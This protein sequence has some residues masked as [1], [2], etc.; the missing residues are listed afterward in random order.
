M[1][2]MV[3]NYRKTLLACYL[4]FVTQAIA[5]NFAP[6]LFLKFHGD[7]GIPLGQIALISTAFFLTQLIVDVLC[8]KFT[9]RIGYRTCVVASSLCF[10]AGLAGLAFLPELFPNPFAGILTSVVIYAVGSGLLE[11]L[12]SPIVEACPFDHKEAVMSLLHSFYCWGSVATIALSTLFFVCFG[13]QNWRI[14]AMLWALLPLVN[15]LVFTQVPLATLTPEG[16]SGLSLGQLFRTPRFWLFLLLMACAG[17]SELS[18]SQWASAFAE[19]AL[20]VSKTVGDLAGPLSFALLMGLSRLVYAAYSRNR[21]SPT[22]FMTAS[23][24]LCIAGYLLVSLSPWPA[25]ALVGCALCGMAVGCMWPGTFSLAA[26]CFPRSGTAL[27]ALL[28][29]AGDLG[30]SA[31]PGL[32]GLVSSAWGDRLQ[33]GL[34]AAAVFPLLLLA[35]LA[36][37]RKT[38]ARQN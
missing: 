6:L 31:G 17:A 15:A 5:A 1:V 8:A 36:V 19:S 28:A 11:V 14:L 22:G 3:K 29:L 23:T 32:V 38:L 7:Y 18:I 26:A 21:P 24:I 37:L 25:L 9:D 10:S 30:C 27:F 2:T 12:G 33:Y 16:E 20:G 4:G 34:L 13:T 35:G